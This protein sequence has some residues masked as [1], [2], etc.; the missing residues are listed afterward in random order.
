MEL[1]EAQALSKQII[2]MLPDDAKA[3]IT[4]LGITY[5]SVAHALDMD[6]T[7]ALNTIKTALEKLPFADDED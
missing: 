1:A 4:V 6:N 2:D 7:D 3:A 5:A